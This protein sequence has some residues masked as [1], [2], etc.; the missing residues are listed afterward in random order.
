MVYKWEGAC[1]VRVTR[2]DNRTL[3]DP[4]LDLAL[5][6]LRPPDFRVR[7]AHN[8]ALCVALPAIYF[9]LIRRFHLRSQVSRTIAS[10]FTF[11]NTGTLLHAQPYAHSSGTANM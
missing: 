7:A 8:A 11:T 6:R 9:L 3:G 1:I 2:G 4:L 5:L 10:G